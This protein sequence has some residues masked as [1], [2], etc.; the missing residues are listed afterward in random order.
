MDDAEA[1][2]KRYL[3]QLGL[4]P[5]GYEPD[6]NCP[7]DLLTANR[8]AVEVRRLNQHFLLDGQAMALERDSFPLLNG[9]R[10]L[11]ESFGPPTDGL[12]WFVSYHFHRPVP[13]WKRIE[14]AVRPVL[15]RIDG[16]R[17]APE[18]TIRPL[19]GFRL[20]LVSCS[21]AQASRFVLGG[22]TDYDS[23]GSLFAKLQ[24]NIQICVDEKAAKIAR[25]RTRY[26]RWWLILVDRTGLGATY[27]ES[28]WILNRI[29]IRHD[30]DRLVVIHPSDS[31]LAVEI[32]SC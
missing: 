1:Q 25:Y 24:S 19:P 13:A 22:Y 23:G 30:L 12:S 21:H 16:A 7:P 14:K 10:R 32:L 11:L 17:V 8:I 18:E 28:S 26:S 5:A 31:S 3:L 4:G 2:A 27:P 15:E 9:M 20:H 6:G 29:Q